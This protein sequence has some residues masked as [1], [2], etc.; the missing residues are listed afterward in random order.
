MIVL[1]SN[2]LVRVVA[3]DDPLQFEAAQRLLQTGQELLVT[4]LVFAETLWVLGSII[5]LNRDQLH[6]AATLV[7]DDPRLSFENLPRLAKATE[8][9]KARVDFTEAYAAATALE[10]KAQGVASFDRDLKKLPVK[11]VRP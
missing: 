2:V 3:G 8:F 7:L 6:Q 4:D 11:W 5:G 9:L 1:D 10:L